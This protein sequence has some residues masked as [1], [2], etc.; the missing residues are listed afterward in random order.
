MLTASLVSALLLTGTAPALRVEI[1]SPKTSLLAFEPVKLT[2]RATALQPVSVPGSVDTTGFPL[3]ETWIDYGQGYVRYAD[4]DGDMREGVEGGRRPL[5][6]GDPFVETLILVNKLDPPSV[7]FPNPGR[8]PLHVVVRLPEG[9]L[10]GESNAITF[11][12]VAPDGDDA[13]VVQQI[14]NQPWVLRG[15]LHDAS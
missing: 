10:L 12:V 2:V 7:P 11:D 8:F 13:A 15:G 6:V 9:V 14:R 1:S 3:L 4:Y 5:K